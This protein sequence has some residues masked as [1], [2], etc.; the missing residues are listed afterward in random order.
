MVIMERH[1]TPDKTEEEQAL[2]KILSYK[3]SYD[4]FNNTNKVFP[5]LDLVN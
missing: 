2:H 5:A 3:Q 1:N 4:W